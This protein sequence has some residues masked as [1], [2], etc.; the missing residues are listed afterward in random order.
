MYQT[1]NCFGTNLNKV[2][3]EVTQRVL[4]NIQPQDIDTLQSKDLSD[5]LKGLTIRKD[6]GS[7]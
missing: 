3:K 2:N 1:W 6:D 7:S 5:C 4:G